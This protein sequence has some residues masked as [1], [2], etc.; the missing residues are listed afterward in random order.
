MA[1]VPKKIIL[2][3]EIAIERDA[4]KVLK[5]LKKAEEYSISSLAIRKAISENP[6]RFKIKYLRLREKNIPTGLNKIDKYPGE[7][8]WGKGKKNFPYLNYLEALYQTNGPHEA[9][10]LF[11]Y[12]TYLNNLRDK[13]TVPG[14]I[15][16]NLPSFAA[17]RKNL[18]AYN[19][20]H[21]KAPKLNLFIDKN[22]GLE[23]A[24]RFA[25]DPWW[26]AQYLIAQLGGI[27][28]G[29]ALSIWDLIKTIP[30][31]I[32]AIY[33][34]I[35]NFD[36]II[37]LSW[38]EIWIAISKDVQDNLSEIFSLNPWEAG[39]EAGKIIGY[40]FVEVI[41]AIISAGTTAA[42]KV[43][44]KVGTKTRKV[45]ESGKKI[46][47]IEEKIQNHSDYNNRLGKIR[48][49][50]QDQIEKVKN[51]IERGPQTSR[52]KRKYNSKFMRHMLEEIR[53]DH[54]L[55]FLVKKSTS[56]KNWRQRVHGK[57]DGIGVQAGH[58]ESLH[59]GPERELFA[60]EDADFN[61][62]SGNKGERQGAILFKEA[63]DVKGIPVE[64]R[65]LHYWMSLWDQKIYNNEGVRIG[66]NPELLVDIKPHKG[67]D[68]LEN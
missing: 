64:T 42:A 35:E 34:I 22:D 3:H 13:D 48:K 66:V 21:H 30:D 54:P 16:L 55:Y 29:A 58:L 68:P 23:F 36:E 20:I 10:V 15:K 61:Q 60:L 65:T 8:T 5:L 46:L 59:S 31:L 27:I 6:R 57:E 7:I 49:K 67:W 41:F 52:A 1:E 40:I 56:K 62:W 39:F 53:E 28:S 44:L 24:I 45:I 32:E 19:F 18:K 4:H 50:S 47:K 17:Y 25:F 51:K 63:Y 37:N 14:Y 26:K 11:Q 38:E 2:L 9:K 43:S 12:V 33:Y